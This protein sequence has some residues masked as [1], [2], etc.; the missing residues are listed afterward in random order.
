[1]EHNI[2]QESNRRNR[3]AKKNLDKIALFVIAVIV[4]I[5]LIFVLINSNINK[6]NVDNK[7]ETNIVDIK[8]DSNEESGVKVDIDN[9]ESTISDEDL[10]LLNN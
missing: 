5:V 2:Y 3:K 6:G 9:I 8:L 7:K 4:L 1:M 10:L